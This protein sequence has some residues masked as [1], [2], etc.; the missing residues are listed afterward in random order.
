MPGPRSRETSSA[1]HGYSV[2][3]EVVTLSNEEFSTMAAVNLPPVLRAVSE[4]P[5]GE[6]GEES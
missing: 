6:K 4:S 2:F 1:L 5:L 3:E